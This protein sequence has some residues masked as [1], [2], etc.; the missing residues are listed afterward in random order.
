MRGAIG[1]RAAEE[2]RRNAY[3]NDVQLGF[4]LDCLKSSFFC[5]YQWEHGNVDPNAV[6]LSKMLKMGYDINY[7]LLGEKVC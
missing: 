5:L 3:E 1:K 6:T 2:I 7:I 4:E